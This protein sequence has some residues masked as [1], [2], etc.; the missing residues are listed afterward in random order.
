MVIT[1]PGA[2]CLDKDFSLAMYSGYAIEI[3]TNLVTID[4]NGYRISNLKGDTSGES[5]AIY[6]YD[7]KNLTIKNGR[8]AGFYKAVVLERDYQ[9]QK[10]TGHL[11]ENLHLNDNS[12]SGIEVAGTYIAV[13]NNRIYS[14]GGHM[15]DVIGA[16]FYGIS[17]NGKGI[18]VEDNMIVTMKDNIQ[19]Y[20]PVAIYVAYDSKDVFVVN[21]RVS[22]SSY[23]IYYANSARGL[24]RDNLV[25]SCS[26]TYYTNGKAIDAGNNKRD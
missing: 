6:A 16:T 3:K 8:I 2:Y 14:T 21:N 4:L 20:Y 15:W 24:Y 9:N 10:S 23:G 18:H 7:R 17:V 12:H 22:D 25:T 19:A 11:I 1:K 13:R 26:S 5:V